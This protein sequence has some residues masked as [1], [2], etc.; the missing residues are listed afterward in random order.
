MVRASILNCATLAWVKCKGDPVN[1]EGVISMQKCYIVFAL[2]VRDHEGLGEYARRSLPTVLAAG[3]RVIA[4][5]ERP[6]VIEGEW[7]GNRTVILEF[8][9]RESASSWYRSGEYQELA[10]LRHAAAATNAVIV[11]GF[12]GLVPS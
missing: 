6:E 8:E 1:N 2:D 10:A 3:G 9:S 5:D 4:V 12:E 7:R 11:S